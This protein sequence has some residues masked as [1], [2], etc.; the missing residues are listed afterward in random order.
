LLALVFAAIV[1]YSITWNRGNKTAIAVSALLFVFCALMGSPDRFQSMKFSMTGIETTARQAIQQVQITLTQL[2]KMELAF[3]RANLSQ[4]ALSGRL[5]VGMSTEDK[6]D[7]RDEIVGSL[8]DTGL[9]SQDILDA[10]TLWI[11]VYC[12]MLL[13]HIKNAATRMFPNSTVQD[14]IEALS[15]D[16]KNT[17]PIPEMIQNWASTKTVRSEEF[18][19]AL[20]EYRN[21]WTTGSMKN[22]ALIPFTEPLLRLRIKKRDGSSQ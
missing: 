4:L 15:V 22:P 1:V 11:D 18:L 3:A 10:Q 2:Q 17:L 12:T 5:L 6:F 8:K 16:S 19:Q 13:S 21:V 7:I 14:E 9:S 20:D